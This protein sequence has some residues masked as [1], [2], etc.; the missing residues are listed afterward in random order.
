MKKPQPCRKRPKKWT[1]R[2][3]D[4]MRFAAYCG[5]PEKAAT[6]VL[7]QMAAMLKPGTELIGRGF[8]PAEQIKAF[9]ELLSDRAAS[10]A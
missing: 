5:L 8:L 4:W 2:R 1:I 10:L 6:R 9:R 3:N 7:D